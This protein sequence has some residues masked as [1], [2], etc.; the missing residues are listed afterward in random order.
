MAFNFSDLT[1]KFDEVLDLV[2]GDL[3][4]I[5]TG[6]AKPSLVEDVMVEA[7]GTRMPIKE[8]GSITAPD[9][10]SIVISLWDQGVVAGVEKA[11]SSGQSQFNPS[12]DGQTVRINIAPL[13]GEKRQELVKLVAQQIES[14]RQM[15]R[16]V[17]TDAKRD[18]EAQAGESGV[19]EDDI[20]ADE[21]ELD[22]LTHEFIGKL[23]VMGKSKEEE[24]LTI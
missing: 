9:P 17:R 21:E 1:K 24:L 16:G 11:L 19:S 18:V 12:V 5:K 7:Y 23:E 15:I 20:K 13:T 10:H 8:L 3:K 22:R 2:D 14:G 4:G 6:R